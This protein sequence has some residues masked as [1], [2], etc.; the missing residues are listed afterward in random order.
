MSS[1]RHCKIKIDSVIKHTVY[2]RV[3][4]NASS[5][6]AL[7]SDK[8]R[9]HSMRIFS[10]SLR[11]EI[12]PVSL[13]NS[14]RVIPSGVDSLYKVSIEGF[15]SPRSKSLM[16]VSDTPD[17]CE[18]LYTLIFFDLRTSF[19]QFEIYPQLISYYNIFIIV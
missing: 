6:S 14:G 17:S 10:F 12:L 7:S 3:F 19:N 11:Y 1:N 8:L 13:S 18:S 2:T 9:K 16:C 4:R 15:L 5:E